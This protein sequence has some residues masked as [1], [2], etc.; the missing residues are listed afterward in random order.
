MLNRKLLEEE[1]G[2]GREYSTIITKVRIRAGYRTFKAGVKASENWHDTTD[3]SKKERDQL[4]AR[5][6]KENEA[7]GHEGK[8]AIPQIAIALVCPKTQ[9]YG[10]HVDKW[11]GDMI[12]AYELWTDDYSEVLGPSLDQFNLDTGQE[13]WLRIGQKVSPRGGTRTAENGK[14]YKKTVHYIAEV[15][16]TEADAMLAVAADKEK[17]GEGETSSIIY[18]P[19]NA[20]YTKSQWDAQVATV[21]KYLRLGYTPEAIAGEAKLPN[22]KFGF[23]VPVECIACL[24][25]AETIPA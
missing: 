20:G 8:K 13:V 15:F 4:K 17:A 25:E 11:Q 10:E 5:I 23:G 22:G 2:E 14:E 18:P 9:S 21:N 3:L 7:A 24:I 12:F 6:R 19:E 16:A 1:A